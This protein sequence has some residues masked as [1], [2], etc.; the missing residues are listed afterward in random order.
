MFRSYDHL[1]A[2]IRVCLSGNYA[3][4]NCSV[5]IRMLVTVMS[6][7][8]RT[9]CKMSREILIKRERCE[10]PL[11]LKF[12]EKQQREWKVERNTPNWLKYVKS[13]LKFLFLR[14]A[15]RMAAQW[16]VERD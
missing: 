16:H 2:E 15:L 4:D 12:S 8:D 3:T 13:L 1:Q 6:R 14:R 7:E 10:I 5:V 11:R 9:L